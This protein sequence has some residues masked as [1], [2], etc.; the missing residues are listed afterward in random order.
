[1][2]SKVKIVDPAGQTHEVEIRLEDYRE[3]ANLG[4]SLPQLYARRYNTPD[5]FEQMCAQA[6]LLMGEEPAFGFR[7]T[8]IS[9]ALATEA[10]VVSPDGSDALGL[11]GRLL[12]P[13]T[14]LMMVEHELREN[15]EGYLGQFAQLI[16]YTETVESARYDQPVINLSAPRD[17]RSQPISQGALPP[18]MVT[19]TLAEKTFRIPTVAIGIQITDEAAR[20]SSLPLV[21]LAIRE[22]A[23][24][25]R[26]AN[27]ERD[28]KAIADGDT[29]AG[30]TALSSITAQSLDSTISGAGALTQKA[31]IKYLYKEWKR[32][33]IDFVIC[34]LDSYLA[35]EGRTGRPTVTSDRGND[36]RL[37]TIPR[38]TDNRI[39]D[40]V[41]IF[42]LDDTSILGANT[43]LGL[44]SSKAI[45]K[46]VNVSATYEAI[47]AVVLRRMTAMRFD[48]AERHER[49]FDQAFEKMTLTV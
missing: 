5:A 43:L 32:R 7:P 45:R 29:D 12:Y 33:K 46:V 3:A 1:M 28:L 35:I 20:H 11:A 4:L 36:E 22:Q 27:I 44:D 39:P 13:A 49:I 10:S 30:M 8:K 19:I 16:A 17:S 14:I 31:W 21:A 41:G 42:L 40:S 23:L 25:E 6:G 2:K 18:Q 38:V 48:F 34:D 47:E 15:Q 37:N 26:V 24:A 9:A